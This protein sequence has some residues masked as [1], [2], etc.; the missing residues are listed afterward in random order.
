M[1]IQFKVVV[2]NPFE[3]ISDY[4]KRLEDSF[5]KFFADVDN[6]KDSWN[7]TYF[8]GTGTKTEHGMET[9]I[10]YKHIKQTKKDIGF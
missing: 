3:S 8:S 5:N 2:K 9:F 6:E 4:E 1:G 7:Y 10:G